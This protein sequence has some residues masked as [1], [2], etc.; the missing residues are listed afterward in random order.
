ML[1]KIEDPHSETGHLTKSN[2]HIPCSPHQNSNIIP[3]EPERAI[4]NFIWKNKKP[5]IVKRIL[6]NKRILGGITIPD[7]NLRY[8][9]IV[10]KPHRV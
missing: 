7:L 2:L 6:D 10:I 9:V 4:L 8:W 3:T 5:R 1:M